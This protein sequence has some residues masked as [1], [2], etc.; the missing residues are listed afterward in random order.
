MSAWLGFSFSWFPS[1]APEVEVHSLLLSRCRT[2]ACNMYAQDL[3]SSLGLSKDP[4]EDLY[5]YVCGSWDKH[6]GL[7]S[8]KSTAEDRLYS[9]ALRAVFS[10]KNGQR[11]STVS[12][13]VSALVRSCM[14]ISD[15]VGELVQFLR[16]RNLPWPQPP[17]ANLLSVLM[18]LSANWNTHLWFHVVVSASPD[19]VNATEPVIEFR[20][21]EHLLTWLAMLKT[22][23][24]TSGY[25]HEIRHTLQLFGVSKARGKKLLRTIKKMNILIG[26]VLG[27]AATDDDS[28]SLDIPIG[29]LSHQLTPK[30]STNTWL[31]MF[32]ECSLC[33]GRL[34]SADLVRIRIPRTIRAIAHL[35]NLEPGIE[36]SLAL[37][38]GFRL[39][40]EIGW[41]A[42]R[43]IGFSADGTLGFPE[44]THT[45]KCMEQVRDMVGTAWF[46]I[47]PLPADDDGLV[48]RIQGVL[49]D[50]ALPSGPTTGSLKL[51]WDEDLA[52]FN[53][54]DPGDS[55]FANWI[56]Y[57]QPQW[58]ITRREST[59]ILRVGVSQDRDWAWE[60]SVSVEPELFSYPFFH[61]DL[62][63][64]INYGGAGRMLA[65]ELLQSGSSHPNGKGVPNHVLD[66]LDT[67][68]LLA[69]LSAFR[70]AED[71]RTTRFLERPFSS[72]A[73]RLFFVASCYVLCSAEGASQTSKARNSCNDAVRGLPEF[74]AAFQCASRTTVAPKT[75][76]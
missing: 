26:A 75:D 42:T 36:D 66:T 50:S 74:R 33:S 15:N 69:S 12:G 47:L 38:L 19:S 16:E 62:P 13:K 10:Q 59:R 37:S 6:A 3:K 27:A 67:T 64:A 76:K 5:G 29:S 44:L 30:V 49:R 71:S 8:V 55:F 34:S 40:Q 70:Q 18:D 31:L 35:L 4:C 41:M 23:G 24:R 46:T 2:P 58:N 72:S 45:R 32:N 7:S 43:A 14:N 52:A 22:L 51:P 28:S 65:R 17:T 73:S 39:L 56:S 54:P 11:L 53:L 25:H 1:L 20:K 60:P 61:S 68:S 57:R 48:E 9:S 21:S 63:R